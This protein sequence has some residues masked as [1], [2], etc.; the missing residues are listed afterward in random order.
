MDAESAY[1][2]YQNNK[3]YLPTTQQILSGANKTAE[4]VQ[5]SGVLKDEIVTGNKNPPK[6][7]LLDP[8]T[9]LFGKSSKETPTVQT[10]QPVNK[11]G[12]F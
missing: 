3:Q 9:S 1:K 12:Q 11:K 2:L 10:Q 5:N 8:L 7:G 4:V 6:K